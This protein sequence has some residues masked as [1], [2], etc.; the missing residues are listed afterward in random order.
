MIFEPECKRDKGRCE[1]VGDQFCCII[2][3]VLI[4]F[5][6]LALEG[7]G[8]KRVP[9]LINLVSILRIK[10]DAVQCLAVSLSFI[11]DES[12]RQ[13]DQVIPRMAVAF[14]IRPIGEE[15][16]QTY[17]IDSAPFPVGGRSEEHTS[18]LQS[19]ENL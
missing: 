14:V 16:I 19:R 13:V 5:S 17:R 15:R 11:V 12:I 4:S 6:E 18:E 1:Y 8:S 7:K 10:E 9:L 3:R 2:I